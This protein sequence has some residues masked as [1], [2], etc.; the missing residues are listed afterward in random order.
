MPDAIEEA[1]S[2]AFILDTRSVYTRIGTDMSS[3]LALGPIDVDFSSQLSSTTYR[4]TW[5]S[6]V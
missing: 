5:S 1:K 3:L 2:A 6:I 4:M